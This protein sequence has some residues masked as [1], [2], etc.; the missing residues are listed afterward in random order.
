[1]TVP[2]PQGYPQ[3]QGDW[4]S[5]TPGWTDP[6]R[7]SGY[8]QASGVPQQ[9]NQ[10]N[11]TDQPNQWNRPQPLRQ[12][13]PQPM[14]AARP[15]PVVQPAVQ[16]SVGVR[17]SPQA[18]PTPPANASNASAA[19]VPSSQPA[20]AQ[21]PV[22]AQPP[23]S[24]QPVNHVTATPVPLRSASQPRPASLAQAV[25]QAGGPR[26]FSNVDRAC[27][28]IDSVVDSAVR[29]GDKERYKL[30]LRATGIGQ[31]LANA[32]DGL[33]MQQIDIAMHDMTANSGLSYSAALRVTYD[34]FDACGVHRALETRKVTRI[35]PQSNEPVIVEERV[36][37]VDRDELDELVESCME[38]MHRLSDD[39]RSSTDEDAYS[40]DCMELNDK[41][42]KLTA[43]GEPMGFY[44]L[45]ECY[46]YGRC[47]TAQ[48]VDK[49]VECLTVAA[50]DGHA[51]A[52]ALLGDINYGEIEGVRRRPD[53]TAAYEYYT[54]P[55][56]MSL[57]AS[58]RVPA[59]KTIVGERANSRLMLVFSAVA[60]VVEMLI[61]GL[62]YG[63]ATGM[64][65]N[66]TMF[67][68]CM[69]LSAVCVV[70]GVLFHRRKPYNG[71]RVVL[72]AVMALWLLGLILLLA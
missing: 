63:F 25:A 52:A 47:G 10:T 65:L 27:A 64:E 16:P 14:Q 31:L 41:L 58:R 57:L 54:R 4:P 28:M 17:T 20:A 18:Y 8:R 68:V 45:G 67:L 70:L 71:L 48:N 51:A 2:Q 40:A 69:A 59:L 22:S 62:L 46:L 66:V 3:P 11:Q 43:M 39:R 12:G 19:A 30:A 15:Q 26:V 72:V 36:F 60:I 35:T 55:G 61:G 1:M 44:M 56:A 49:A 53:Y 24:A 23:T 21:G 9:A 29:P 33:A 37:P 42:H 7:A 50:D 34:L 13:R 38:L 32:D 6:R 5:P